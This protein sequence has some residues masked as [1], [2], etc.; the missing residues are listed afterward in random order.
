[1]IEKFTESLRNT[2]DKMWGVFTKSTSIFVSSI[3]LIFSLGMWLGWFMAG[4]PQHRWVLMVPPLL[5]VIAYYY[6][7]FATILFI[8]FV[9]ALIL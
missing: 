3:F 7:T 8:I 5:G 9:L 4:F 6:R 1:M 2:F